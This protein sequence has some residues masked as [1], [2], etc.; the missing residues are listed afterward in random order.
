MEVRFKYDRAWHVA[1]I[2]P[3]GGVEIERFAPL[4]YDHVSGEETVSVGTASWDPTTSRLSS[5]DLRA[6]LL[7]TASRAI[8]DAMRKR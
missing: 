5:D 1:R 7:E 3:T 2:D 8:A 6:S 4:S